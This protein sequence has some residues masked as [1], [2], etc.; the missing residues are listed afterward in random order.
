MLPLAIRL[1]N[2]IHQLAFYVT[3]KALN[4]IVQLL[5]PNGDVIALLLITTT[6]TAFYAVKNSLF[7]CFLIVLKKY[8]SF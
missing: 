4:A 1:V 5:C 2:A 6:F 8:F 7:S 3:P